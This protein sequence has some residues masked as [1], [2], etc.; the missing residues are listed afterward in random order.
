MWVRAL[1][2]CLVHEI[3]LAIRS[4]QL[5]G[6]DTIV[7]IQDSSREREQLLCSECKLPCPC[8]EETLVLSILDTL[9]NC[10]LFHDRVCFKVVCY[11]LE[12]KLT[13]ESE[14]CLI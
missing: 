14:H 4:S 2:H 7:L 6:A 1:P 11:R 8:C 12:C 13:S 9:S 3:Y 10:E 5:L